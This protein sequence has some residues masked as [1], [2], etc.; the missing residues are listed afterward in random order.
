MAYQVLLTDELTIDTIDAFSTTLKEALASGQ[1][2]AID[3]RGVTRLDTAAAQLLVAVQKEAAQS[4]TPCTF[5][6]SAAV[7]QYLHRI[8]VT[9]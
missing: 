3:L 1:S 6:L 2:L 9:L 7:T 5:H 4:G 8:G